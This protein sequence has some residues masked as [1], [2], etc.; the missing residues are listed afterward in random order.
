MNLMFWKKKKAPE[1]SGDSVAD[2]TLA[3][4]KSGPTPE[5]PGFW[6]R[7]KSTLS[8]SHKKSE[9]DEAEEA[10][11]SARRKNDSRP[12][13]GERDEIPSRKSHAR[14]RDEEPEA[15]PPKPGFLARLKSFLLPSRKKVK[16]EDEEKPEKLRPS[17]K[18]PDK[19]HRDEEPIPVVIPAKKSSKRL[20]IVLAL[21]IPLAAGIG[22]F[23]ANQF[24]SPQ[25]QKA[26][27]NDV[28][29]QEERA[30]GKS[31]PGPAK[32]AEQA[33]EPEQPLTEPA[34]QQADSATPPPAEVAEPSA[35]TSAADAPTPVDERVQEQIEAM[36]KQNQEMQAQ[37]EALKKRPAVERSVRPAPSATP[38]EG[39]LIINGKDAKE[40][41]QGVKK[42][43]EGMNASSGAKDNGK[44]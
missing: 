16:T 19:K 38:R 41:A 23:A 8:P 14:H 10:K 44:K 37:I 26:P 30:N 33:P 15:P 29:W 3:S 21:L 22:F 28:A 18:S 5:K 24:P 27:T 40:S 6:A 12:P 35:E 2:K 7:L 39:V 13:E 31:A 1:E 42:I 11:P 34:P 20:V 25:N 36:K 9:P 17:A 4:R 43:I 32:T